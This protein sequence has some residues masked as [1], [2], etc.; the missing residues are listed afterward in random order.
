MPF[1]VVDADIF[2]PVNFEATPAGRRPL[3][4][5]PGGVELVDQDVPLV[6]LHPKGMGA[7]GARAAVI[8]RQHLPSFFD[9]VR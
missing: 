9:R 2:E 4:D 3:A 1:T 6:T 5:A 7:E 8:G